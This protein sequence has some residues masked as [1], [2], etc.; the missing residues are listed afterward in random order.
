[1]AA[2]GRGRDWRS[3]E[4]ACSLPR[5]TLV[6]PYCKRTRPERGTNT[7]VA[8]FP[9]LS[10]PSPGT[11]FPP[12]RSASRQPIWAGARGDISLIGP[13][14]PRY[15]N[16]D[17]RDWK[18]AAAPLFSLGV[19]SGILSRHGFRQERRS[20]AVYMGRQSRS[21]LARWAR[22]TE[23]CAGRGGEIG[24]RRAILAE[25]TVLT[26]RAHAPSTQR[27]APRALESAWSQSPT[28]QRVERE[29]S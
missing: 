15:R 6:T 29:G 28:A 9:P 12:S 22:F 13:G 20:R 21:H 27:R 1:L 2:R 19:S 4:A 10:R 11:F 5:G 23:H 17:R 25:E 3:R 16:V 18:V 26:H 8:G 24:S 7:K 14:T